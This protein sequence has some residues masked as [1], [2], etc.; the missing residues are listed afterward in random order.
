[1]K[2]RSIITLIFVLITIG[3]IIFALSRG[4]Y[5]D[6]EKVKC[7]ASKSILYVATGCSACNYQKNLFGDNFKYL[8][9]IDCAVEPEKCQNIQY[10]PTWLI[11]NEKY[12]GAQSIEK[13][14]EVTGC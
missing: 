13:L 1:M 12:Q 6:K 4:N 7:I 8:N 14:K 10:V 3:I 5:S 9:I 2:K 11:N